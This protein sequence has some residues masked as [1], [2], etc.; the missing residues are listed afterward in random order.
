MDNAT[1]TNPAIYSQTKRGIVKIPQEV[2][3]FEEKLFF[4]IENLLKDIKTLYEPYHLEFKITKHKS[5]GRPILRLHHM[6]RKKKLTVMEKVK[7]LFDH[8]NENWY[9]IIS[10]GVSVN[11]SNTR[12]NFEAQE[13][14]IKIK[15]IT[16][17]V[18][19]I[20]EILKTIQ[21]S[22]EKS[23]KS[24]QEKTKETRRYGARIAKV[25]KIIHK[26]INRSELKIIKDY[27]YF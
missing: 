27:H 12:P 16:T 6:N 4:T 22:V 9:F 20:E 25:R 14:N 7:I 11:I 26:E 2:L 24:A 23:K 8:K 18:K 13:F 17:V 21:I 19:R 5:W 1:K 15:N 3:D 10:Q